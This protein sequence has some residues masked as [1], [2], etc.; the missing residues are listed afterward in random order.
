MWILCIFQNAQCLLGW[1]YWFCFFSDAGIQI[2][3]GIPRGNFPLTNGL[4]ISDNPSG[5]DYRFRIFCRSDSMTGNVGEFIGLDG[6]VLSSNSI[7]S[8]A[9]PQAGE[10]RVQNRVGSQS[11]L[12]ASQEGVYTC[13]I[14]LQNGEIREIN[15]GVY[16]SGF[17]SE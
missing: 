11:S 7:F 3:R 5:N 15:V 2:F 9:N 16:S 17:N 4:V 12:T 8:I 13:R 14:P 6:N 1:D 10:L